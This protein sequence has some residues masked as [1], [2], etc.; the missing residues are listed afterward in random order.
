MFSGFHAVAA[1]EDIFAVTK[2]DERDRLSSGERTGACT[3]AWATPVSF[4]T[5]LPII[6][7]M[8]PDPTA[9]PAPKF[10]VAGYKDCHH[11]RGL[12]KRILWPV[13]LIEHLLNHVLVSIKPKTN[14]PFV[15][16]PS[17]VAIDFQL[18]IFLM[19]AYSSQPA[20]SCFH[21]ECAVATPDRF[22]A[23]CLH[24]VLPGRLR[25]GK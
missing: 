11:R 22:A 16:P 24:A 5:D 13:P 4:I 1:E 8:T 21:D 6:A 15:C 9:C 7:G 2:R 25:G 3:P 10:A 14:R 19:R 23:G 12:G 17:R 18:R 20:V